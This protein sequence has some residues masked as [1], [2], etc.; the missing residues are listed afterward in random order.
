V[1]GWPG[2][3]PGDATQPAAAWRSYRTV[4]AMRPAESRSPATS[5]I[6]LF[7]AGASSYGLGAS[8]GVADVATPVT[9]R[10]VVPQHDLDAE[11]PGGRTR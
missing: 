1:Q 9:G 4:F 10:A 3:I 8:I 2:R 7:R 11:D 5:L 6:D